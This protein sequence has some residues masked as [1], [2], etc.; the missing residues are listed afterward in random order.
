M[1]PLF[2]RR[3]RWRGLTIFRVMGKRS[4][5]SLRSHEDDLPSLSLYKHGRQDS[6]ITPEHRDVVGRY[7]YFFLGR[8][9]LLD[10]AKINYFTIFVKFA[11]S[12]ETSTISPFWP[13]T[14][15]RMGSLNLVVSMVFSAPIFT[16]T[17]DPS[18][19]AFQP[20]LAWNF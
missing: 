18:T 20:L 15:P 7:G 1:S 2:I 17:T 16:T 3:V 5:S 9:N 10:A 6:K 11:P 12:I 8:K 4:P 13:K 19:P 14:N